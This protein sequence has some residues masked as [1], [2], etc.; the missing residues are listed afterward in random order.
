M[1]AESAAGKSKHHQL[2]AQA[3]A[4]AKAKKEEELL[5]SEKGTKEEKASGVKDT[6]VGWGW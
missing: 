3:R 2:Q 4:A 1:V 5:A 6:T